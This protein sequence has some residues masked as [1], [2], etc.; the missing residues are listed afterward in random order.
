MSRI[1]LLVL[2]LVAA[3]MITHAADVENMITNPSFED[4]TVSIGA[5]PDW[6]SWVSVG[7]AEVEFSEEV[8]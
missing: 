1:G 4:D 2:C 8:N 6:I 7:N 5:D 3:P